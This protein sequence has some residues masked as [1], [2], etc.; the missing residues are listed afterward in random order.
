MREY[1]IITLN[2]FKNY[3][4]SK[5]Y[6]AV[7]DISPNWETTPLCTVVV[8]V[9][10]GTFRAYI[11]GGAQNENEILG[12]VIVG[13]SSGCIALRV[14]K[15]FEHVLSETTSVIIRNAIIM[16]VQDR[17]MLE[18]CACTSIESVDK[19]RL[20]ICITPNVS[21]NVSV[22]EYALVSHANGD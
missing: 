17:V 14:G 1:T 2:Q 9:C 22:I 13:D 3:S 12:E 6:T 10:P 18:T 4:M 16:I 5:P 7:A 11:G 15:Q 19:R 20:G 8:A 21:N